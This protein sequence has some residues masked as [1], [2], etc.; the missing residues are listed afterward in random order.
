MDELYYQSAVSMMNALNKREVSSRELT[1]AHLAR[2]EEVNP[3]IN[4]VVLVDAEGA[5]ATADERDEE[6]GKGETRGPLHGLPIT[7]KDSLET[8]GMATVAGTEGR[9]GVVPEQDATVVARLKGGR[10]S[11]HGQEQHPRTDH[12]LGEQQL[13]LRPHQ[14]P[15]RPLQESQRE[16]R[17]R[18]SY[19]CRRW[20]APG[21]GLRQ[22]RQHPHARPLLR[23]RRAQTHPGPRLPGWARASPRHGRHRPP[24]P[25]GP[26]G[27]VR[28]GPVAG[29][30][31]DCR[32]G[33]SGPGHR[34]HATVRAQNRWTCGVFDASISRESGTLCRTLPPSRPWRM[35]LGR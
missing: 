5:L 16:Q 14:Q 8:A 33:W 13:R 23:H 20:L 17:R 4:A 19:H 15:L 35:R 11:P 30:A 21:H 25:G 28:R 3:A 29:A 2:I 32:G 18:R 9:T 1:E 34:A 22:R 12:D 6:S 10:S 31:G 27:P 26:H 7:I 24:Q